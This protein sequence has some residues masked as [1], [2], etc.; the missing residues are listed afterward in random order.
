MQ[1][2]IAHT[3][4]DRARAQQI[5]D[6]Y[7]QEARKRAEPGIG[8]IMSEVPTDNVVRGPSLQF[9]AEGSQVRA[10]VGAYEQTYGIHDNA[11][12]QLAG[13]MDI[14]VAYVRHLQNPE[15]AS[16]APQLLAHT[17]SE[18]TTR[19]MA[20]DRV[21]V[22]EYAGTLR[23]VLS[24]HFRRIDCRPGFDALIG[25]AQKAGALV[26]DAIVTDVRASVRL[27]VPKVQELSPGEFAVFGLAWS[28]S[29]YG[30]GAQALSLFALRVWCLNGATLEQAL[31]QVHLGGR[32]T[33]NIA[34]SERTMRLDSAATASAIRDTARAL[35]APASMDR[36]VDTIKTAAATEV[37]G[38]A[39]ASDLRKRLGKGIAEAVAE[40]YNTADVEVL[41]PG[42]TAWR[43]C[44]AISWV[45]KQDTTDAETRIDLE[46]EAGAVLLARK[47][48]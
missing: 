17:L 43:W 36:V 19:A 47:S 27:L 46:R 30:K 26:T 12:T 2:I 35:L 22:R 24:D 39:R 34:Y 32:L 13:R 33:D 16:W 1:P 7:L 23:A 25:E 37:D 8:R 4:H 40:A 48:V 41:P 10:R 29:D 38:K 42:N 20:R 6:S 3:Q 18:H 11:M 15:N 44:N 31:R 5:L 28:N 14:P 9:V 45:A 21:L